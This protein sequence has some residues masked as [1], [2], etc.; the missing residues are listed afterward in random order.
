LH[1]VGEIRQSAD[2]KFVSAADN[3]IKL[4]DDSITS[5]ATNSIVLSS[6]NHIVHILDSNSNNDA[7]FIIG[8]NDADPR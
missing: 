7:G 2:E 3:Y 8:G 5:Y 6:L 4:E 1:V